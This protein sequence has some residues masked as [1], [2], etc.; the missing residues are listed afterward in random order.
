MLEKLNNIIGRDKY[1]RLMFASIAVLLAIVA[2]IAFDFI[3]SL[4]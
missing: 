1:K 3:M 2:S 4:I